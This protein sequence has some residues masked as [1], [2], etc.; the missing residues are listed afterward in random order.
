MHSHSHYSHDGDTAPARLVE[1]AAAKNI[2]HLAVTDHN[3]VEANA[4]ALRAG[5]KLGVAVIPG[6][7]LD[8]HYQEANLH[9]LG[10]CIDFHDKRYPELWEDIRARKSDNNQE[11]IRLVRELGFAVDDSVMNGTR[12]GVLPGVAIGE[13]ILAHPKNAGMAELE[14]FRPG[15]AKAEN[16]V[17]QFCWAYLTKGKPGYVEDGSLTLD[18]AVT[19]IVSTGGIPVLA[20]PGSSIPDH[21]DY[22][23]E[24]IAAGVAGVEVFCGYHAPETAE[25]WRALAGAENAFIT[26]GSDYHGKMKPA[27]SLGVHGGDAFERDILEN[28]LQLHACG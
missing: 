21:E 16:P 25:R 19:L 24:I 23:P 14:P 27:I 28:V 3:R 8:C 17:I 7:E 11:R 22:L 18:E 20:H 10:Y 6:I 12:D 1:M 26:C 13:H 2:T 9:L 5:E 4:E 15:G